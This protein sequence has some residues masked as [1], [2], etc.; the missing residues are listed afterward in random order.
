VQEGDRV[1]AGQFLLQIDPVAADS[2]V[3]RDEAAV[4]GARTGLEQARVQLKSAEASLNLAR[5]QSKR[6]QDLWDAGLTTRETFDQAQA[7]L[8]VRESDLSAREQ[9][10]RTRQENLRQQEAGLLSS[11]HTLAQ[12]RFDSP[13][14]GIVTRR[15]IEEGE[16]VVV[17]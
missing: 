7:E 17:G 14:D 3:R 15:N 12:A 6:Q 13:F 8:R 5:Q 4:A 16:N 9:E 1:K 11:R 2:A 10:I